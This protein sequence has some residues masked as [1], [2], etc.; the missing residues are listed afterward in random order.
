MPLTATDRA[1]FCR[2]R[3][4]NLI[5]VAEDYVELTGDLIAELGEA[6]LTDIAEHLGVTQATALRRDGLVGNKRCRSIILTDRGH[7]ID[8]AS[9]ARHRIVF[10]F[11]VALGL[12]EAVAHADPMAENPL[13]S[14][15]MAGAGYLRRSPVRARQDRR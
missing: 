5:E 13:T 11:L 14:R 6:R 2:T 12:D 7:E 4:V 1:A 9:R 8:D 10:D 15:S 3:E